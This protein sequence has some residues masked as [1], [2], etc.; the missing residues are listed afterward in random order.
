MLDIA[1]LSRSLTAKTYAQPFQSHT[2]GFYK[3]WN[4]VSCL[5][6]VHSHIFHNHKNF[7]IYLI[8]R[9]KILFRIN[10][11]SD[12]RK[13]EYLGFSMTWSYWLWEFKL[14]YCESLTE[15]LKIFNIVESV[16]QSS[17]HTSFLGHH[18]SINNKLY[19]INYLNLSTLPD[20]KRQK[21]NIMWWR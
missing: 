15:F 9:S 21:W 12:I 6:S 17:D 2:K 4:T 11:T 1:Y 3:N 20:E 14:H 16:T 10:N 5:S 8:T 18:L 7:L 19:V 13:K